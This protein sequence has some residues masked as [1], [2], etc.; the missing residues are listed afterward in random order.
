MTPKMKVKR[1]GEAR[2]DFIDFSDKLRTRFGTPLADETIESSTVVE[3]GTSDLTI[4][5][6]DPVGASVS[7]LVSG[8]SAGQDYTVM[9]EAVTS[10]GQTLQR[11]KTFK[12]I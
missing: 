11:R 4:T 10:E 7:Y 12:V 2:I 1:E 8:G 6:L 9:A 3:V 5:D